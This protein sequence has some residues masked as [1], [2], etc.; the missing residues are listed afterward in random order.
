MKVRG[1]ICRAAALVA[2]NAT[3]ALTLSALH[4]V[5]I[6]GEATEACTM[7]SPHQ[8]SLSWLGDLRMTIRVNSRSGYYV[9]ES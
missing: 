6:P 7:L 2:L 5:A 4:P 8:K 9:C 3:L 1:W